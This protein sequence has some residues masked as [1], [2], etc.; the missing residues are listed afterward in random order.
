MIKK[1]FSPE[2]R[3]LIYEIEYVDP[4]SSQRRREDLAFARFV[5]ET[6]KRAKLLSSL[7][8]RNGATYR[9]MES[10]PE[11][12]AYK[13]LERNIEE[14]Q[15]IL[16]TLAALDEY[17]RSAVEPADRG[18]VRSIKTELTTIKG[19]V[20]K[21]NQKKHEYVA[22]REEQEQMRRLGIRSSS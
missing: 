6:G 13:F 4:L 17:F 20:I 11:D 14:L 22:Q 18:R 21:A 9:R 1:I 8:Q 5:E 7:I 2:D 12:Q 10:M 3:G 15:K 19:A 16:R